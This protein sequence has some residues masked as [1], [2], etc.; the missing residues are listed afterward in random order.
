M[1]RAWVVGASGMLGQAVC[2]ALAEAGVQPMGTASA[3]DVRDPAALGAAA[4]AMRDAAPTPIAAVFNCAAMT[5]VD[6]CEQQREQAMA[7]NADGAAHVAAQAIAMGAPLVHVSTD[8]VFGGAPRAP[9]GEEAACSP[10]NVYGLSKRRG[11]ELLAVAQAAAPGAW[12]ATVRTSWLFGDT[13]SHFV[14]TMLRLM[15]QRRELKV[16]DDQWGRP[17][18][19]ADLAAAMLALVGMTGRPRATPG[20]YHFANHG[21]TTWHAFAAE[22]WRHGRASGLPLQLQRLLPVSSREFPQPA[23][24]PAYSVLDT[25]KIE[26][27]LGAT[28]RSWQAALAA[29]MAARRHA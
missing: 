8:Y 25:G 21:P 23:P 19:A 27:A 20:I 24:R 7:I 1:R 26:A 11:E 22:I 6:A 4:A 29:H 12:A 16:V 5:Q 9:L 28:P 14:A 10:P 3:C 2:Q 13:G 18:Y 17:T 15:G